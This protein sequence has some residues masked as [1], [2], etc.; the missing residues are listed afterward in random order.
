MLICDI[1]LILLEKPLVLYAM[2][3]IEENLSIKRKV[4]VDQI[5]SLLQNK[6]EIEK[7]SIFLLLH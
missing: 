7:K 1:A 6:Q 3:I 4:E 5:I 2:A